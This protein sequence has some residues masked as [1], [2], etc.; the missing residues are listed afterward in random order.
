MRSISLPFQLSMELADAHEYHNV[1]CCPILRSHCT[2]TNPPM[3]LDCGHA[4]SKDAVVKLGQ[5]GRSVLSP[6]L[7]LPSPSLSS[8]RTVA[9]Q[10][11]VPLLPPGDGSQIAARAHLLSP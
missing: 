1:F 2:I 9:L 6:F 10:V 4:V 11:E 8:I 7:A 5:A 3:R